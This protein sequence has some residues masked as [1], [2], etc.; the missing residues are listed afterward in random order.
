[1]I[2]T[3]PDRLNPFVHSLKKSRMAE[4][5]IQRAIYAAA[6]KNTSHFAINSY[7][8]AVDFDGVDIL[9][10]AEQNSA[11]KYAAIA[12]ISGP[13]AVLNNGKMNSIH[14]V[15]RRH[16]DAVS[17]YFLAIQNQTDDSFALY[18]A[19]NILSQKVRSLRPERGAF[20]SADVLI[21]T[22]ISIIF[23]A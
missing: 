17:P 11:I 20:M 21:D 16:T 23:E 8:P 4:L 22:I 13:T 9:L 2:S 6:L 1:M 7:A 10:R 3:T 12:V 18:S 5:T 14:A 15:A 19:N